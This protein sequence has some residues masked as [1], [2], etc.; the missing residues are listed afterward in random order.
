MNTNHS[1]A[2]GTLLLRLSLGI[3][4]LA[5]GLLKLLV[6]TPSGTAQ[7]FASVGFPGF[8]GYITILAEV[9]GGLALILGLW[10]RAISLLLVPLM[11]GA[12]TVHIGNGWVFS[13]AGGGWEFPVF[14]TVT[15]LVQFLLGSGPYAL[16]LSALFGKPTHSRLNQ[17][18]V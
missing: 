8:F 16:G 15:L 5:H 10:T 13:V 14:W 11:I 2:Y 3:M 7:Y 18:T 17:G 6:F 12:T 9:G 4:F 1:A